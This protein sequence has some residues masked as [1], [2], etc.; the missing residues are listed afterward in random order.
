MKKKWILIVFALVALGV[1]EGC[2]I[3]GG[4][5]CYRD[6]TGQWNCTGEPM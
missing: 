6:D 4:D 5:G 3:A 2:S 1:L